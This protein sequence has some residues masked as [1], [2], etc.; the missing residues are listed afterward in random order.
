ME[1]LRE[2]AAELLRITERTDAVMAIY[3][4]DKDLALYLINL[5]CDNIERGAR[6]TKRRE[7]RRLVQP[8]FTRHP[9]GIKSRMIMTKKT[10][11]NVIDNAKKLFGEWMINASISMG[12][13]TKEDLLVQAQRE[14]ASANGHTRNAQ[15]YEALADPMK[16]G[17]TV[18][19]FWTPKN[20]QK[21]KEKI[22]KDSDEKRPDLR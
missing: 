22:W 3:T 1:T 20:A 5:G 11:Q 4:G 13:A 2:R 15:F 9:S 12:E 21:L 19:E 10:Q 17:Q 14:R 8:D 7:L 18:A 16:P 6:A